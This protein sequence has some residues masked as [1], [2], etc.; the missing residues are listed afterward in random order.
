MLK[1]TAQ[2]CSKN[3]LISTSHT[4]LDINPNEVRLGTFGLPLSLLSI[5]QVSG[6]KHLSIGSAF[7][8]C[9]IGLTDG[10]A[11]NQF[12]QISHNSI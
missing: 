12:S 6:M 9:L 10:V 7:I 2:I 8:N 11:D 4:F 1:F 5:C 3:L